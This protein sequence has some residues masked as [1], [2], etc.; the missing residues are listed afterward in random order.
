MLVA[1]RDTIIP[2]NPQGS[3]ARCEIKC[4]LEEEIIQLREETV[5]GGLDNVP[6]PC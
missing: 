3:I 4:R 6:P 5:R 2:S 1:S